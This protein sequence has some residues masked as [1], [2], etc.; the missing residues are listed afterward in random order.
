MTSLELLSLDPKTTNSKE[1]IVRTLGNRWPLSAKEIHYSLL[2]EQ[3][4]LSTY[5][6]THKNLKE[7]E[8][9]GVISKEG[10]KYKLSKDWIAKSKG[11]FDS[12]E[13]SYSKNEYLV[14]SEKIIRFSNYTDFSLALANI[15][16][17]KKLMGPKYTDT[18]VMSRHLF[19][20]LKF[21][22]RDFQLCIS[23]AMNAKPHIICSSDTPFDRLIKKYYGLARWPQV[24]IAG[25]F[26]SEED[27]IVQGHTIMQVKYS[28]STKKK[29]DSIYEKV[30]NFHELFLQYVKNDL[31]DLEIELK[32]TQNPG[33][34]QMMIQ[35]IQ[36]RLGGI[37]D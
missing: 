16:N 18:Y 23:V 36:D 17:S 26:S 12:L 25:N 2:R 20:P 14:E 22:F 5:Q 4:V 29:I 1:L 37:N 13:L 9:L 15:C 30:H 21:D 10:T 32:I 34:A 11:Y 19:W 6:A 8:K 7:L 28:E 27:I 33:L 31:N 3:G 35:N 24:A